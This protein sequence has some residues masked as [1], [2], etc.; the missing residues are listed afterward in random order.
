VPITSVAHKSNTPTSKGVV[1]KVKK[2]LL[3]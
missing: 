2:H 3:P 1:L